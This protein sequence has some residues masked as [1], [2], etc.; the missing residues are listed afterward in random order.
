MT[1]TRT[2]KAGSAA[3]LTPE[4]GCGCR[5]PSAVWLT[6]RRVTARSGNQQSAPRDDPSWR[7]WREDV[8]ASYLM[9]LGDLK[10]LASPQAIDQ[11]DTHEA[12][13][14]SAGG[15]DHVDHHAFLEN[16]VLE[17]KFA[18]GVILYQVLPVA[19]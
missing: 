15:G 4:K 12:K 16:R 17:Q 2:G 13:C 8:L 10:G 11:A 5:R 7:L 19:I 1:S 3:F 14:Q 18:R 6:P 9:T